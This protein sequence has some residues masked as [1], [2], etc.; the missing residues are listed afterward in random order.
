MSKVRR[1]VT[2]E[3]GSSVSETS[4]KRKP[5]V[6]ERLG[7]GASRRYRDEEDALSEKDERPC[8][9]WMNTGSCSYGSSCR[10]SH[11][12]LHHRRDDSPE[13]LRHKMK[14]RK[15]KGRSRE[16]QR[17]ESLSP[18]RRR[19]PEPRKSRRDKDLL[20]KDAG[21]IRSTVVVK[22]SSQSTDSES[23]IDRGLTGGG[24]FNERMLDF[25]QELTLMKRRQ[26]LQ[27]ELSQ[28]QEEE[29]SEERENVRINIHKPG[30]ILKEVLPVFLESSSSS[31][32]DLDRKQK[33]K[34]KDK[35]KHTKMPAAELSPKKK[36][37]DKKKMKTVASPPPIAVPKIRRRSPSVEKVKPAKR[38][39]SNESLLRDPFKKH[40][41]KAKYT[42]LP[43]QESPEPVR[44]KHSASPDRK[45]KKLS[46]L[47]PTAKK[48][49]SRTLSLSPEPKKGKKKALISPKEKDPYDPK[50][51]KFREE[52]TFEKPKDDRPR[53]VDKHR[54]DGRVDKYARAVAAPKRRDDGYFDD[55]ERLRSS[56]RARAV[57]PSPPRDVRG[58]K[59]RDLHPQDQ[60]RK[61]RHDDLKSGNDY[62]KTKGDWQKPAPPPKRRYESSSSESDSD[63]DSSDDSSS[64]S[65]YESPKKTRAKIPEVKGR[66]SKHGSQ[67]S[68]DQER[69][70]EPADH[71]EFDDRTRYS[72]DKRRAGDDGQHRTRSPEPRDVSFDQNR[73]DERQKD[74]RSLQ[75]EDK[76]FDR[77]K[78]HHRKPPVSPEEFQG[79]RG[80]DYDDRDQRRKSSHS[81]GRHDRSLERDVPHGKKD[82]RD[83]R[84]RHGS[85][86][87]SESG[88]DKYRQSPDRRSYQSSDDRS[89][90]DDR[91]RGGDDRTTR[92]D[93][94][95][96]RRD[97][98]YRDE[99]GKKERSLERN[100]RLDQGKEKI[101]R[102]GDRMERGGDRIERGGER[103]DRGGDRGPDRSDRGGDRMERG[104]ERMERNDRME[105]GSDRGRDRSLE[106][107]R[108]RDRN[109][110]LSGELG[111]E[112]SR[113]RNLERAGDRS[114]DRGGDRSM[115][116]GRDRSLERGDRGFERGD[117]E[118]DRGG[119]RSMDRGQDRSL[120][121][122]GDRSMDRGSDRNTDRSSDRNLERSADRSVDRNREARDDER[123]RGSD[124]SMDRRDDER[125]RDPRGRDRNVDSRD[126]DDERRGPDRTRD[127]RDPRDPSRPPVGD[128]RDRPPGGDPRD[129]PNESRQ[130]RRGSPTRDFDRGRRNGQ[131]PVAWNEREMFN[132]DQRKRPEDSRQ[133]RGPSPVLSAR[134]LLER[135]RREGL[136]MELQRGLPDMPPMEDF[137]GPPMRGG[138]GRM[139]LGRF[140]PFRGNDRGRRG[141]WD[142]LEG[143]G[144]RRRDDMDPEDRRFGDDRWSRDRFGEYPG[145]GLPMPPEM[146]GRLPPDW[147]DRRP[148]DRFDDR[149]PPGLRPDDRMRGDDRRMLPDRFDD[150]GPPPMMESADGHYQDRRKRPHDSDRSLSPA[151]KRKRDGS[152]TDSMKS[153]RSERNKPPR[154]DPRENDPG[155]SLDEEA[156]FKT[157]R[158][159]AELSKRKRS[160]SPPDDRAPEDREKKRQRPDSKGTGSES[161]HGSGAFSDWSDDPD[162]I[163][164]KEERNKQRE[165]DGTEPK[166]GRHYRSSSLSSV[167]SRHSKQDKKDKIVEPASP[168]IP[169]GEGDR[170]AEPERNGDIKKERENGPRNGDAGGAVGDDDEKGVDMEYDPISDDELE[171]LIAIDDGSGEQG[172]DGSKTKNTAIVDA[173]DID[174]SSLVKDTRPKPPMS[175][176]ALKRFSPANVLAR[177]GVSRAYAGEALM[178]KLK[179]RCQ[180]MIEEEAKQM[181]LE[182]GERDTETGLK[183]VS[184]DPSA[185]KQEQANDKP[186]KPALVVPKFE[187][188]NDIAFK[189][190]TE[191]TKRKERAN[192]LSNLGPYRRALCARRDLSI[193]RRLC[194]VEKAQDQPPIYN[195]QIDRDLVKLSA[196]LLK[197]AKQTSYKELMG[198][199]ITDV[200]QPTEPLR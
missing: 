136:E 91:S 46:L 48:S 104:G 40:K 134:E 125:S 112:S 39:S 182:N 128:P 100:D 17:S 116:R 126:K 146:M 9:K 4:E 62:S 76:N 147:E 194:K 190:A 51:R 19:S 97:E 8:H 153:G 88:R 105:R 94:G 28:L 70:P 138:R 165:R 36:A 81:P 16:R 35:K 103:L 118:L 178:E 102:G 20:A 89:R 124:R 174:W 132:R 167:G 148:G 109:M 199:P 31:D 72:H 193:R 22:T 12:P 33:G 145:R 187:F 135:E 168:G 179:Q 95:F 43:K 63:S 188:Y 87:R 6:F 3:K 71:R 183:S 82:R 172:E 7:P 161:H 67:G 200:V 113:D 54:D 131:S 26:E 84:E 175:C 157:D 169:A 164:N 11:P 13:D 73:L 192:L 59:A 155:K 149:R 14:H 108:D 106:R 93:R 37:K 197:Q 159:M 117:R 115:D 107:G 173:L 77:T 98:R 198:M 56:D 122:G 111:M 18:E 185:D 170:P 129:R 23:E 152:P 79:R 5:S 191:V 24:E 52:K 96:E 2:V 50:Q 68:K 150:R 158:Y 75:K 83:D 180:A 154:D 78:G 133:R 181:A 53:S 66:S 29:R 119:N 151:Y 86:E 42:T 1:K 85:P 99:R 69:W 64:E 184:V 127:N 15:G 34:S 47:L 137:P 143:R 140:P 41:E 25:E 186:T 121:R 110:E 114:M 120:E 189:H 90:V 195:V 60:Y 166:R 21:K 141:G 171:E 162:E 176:S 160:Q 144:F 55:G 38:H 80:R 44:S 49:K 30:K 61:K 177:I 142:P 130:D 45:Q 57:E 101:E 27:R 58:S 74:R 163:L 123:S 10:Y 92:G 65:E 32:S 139:A 156:K 196:Q